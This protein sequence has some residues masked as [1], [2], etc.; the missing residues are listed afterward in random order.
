MGFFRRL[1]FCSSGRR[2]GIA[3]ALAA[4]LLACSK[5]QSGRADAGPGRASPAPSAAGAVPVGAAP[6]SRPS[7]LDSDVADRL[8]AVRHELGPGVKTEVVGATFVFVSADGGPLFARAV[9]DATRAFPLYLRGRLDHAPERAV[10]VYAFSREDRYLDDCDARFGEPC[11]TPFG[12]YRPAGRVI[13]VNL[14]RGTTTI[15]HEMLH[16]MTQRDFPLARRWLVEGLGSLYETPSFEPPGEIH[17]VT[18]WRLPELQRALASRARTGEVRL[19]RL[20]ATSDA[21]FGQPEGLLLRQATA[22]F[23]CQWLDEQGLLWPF[24]RQWRDAVASDPAGEASFARVV[25]TTPA[26]ASE[27]WRAWV[28]GLVVPPR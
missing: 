1:A 16:P 22:R 15:L 20:F 10:T 23:V 24:Y 4:A 25:G 13:E 6:P 11:D 26:E 8:A 12:Q 7:S 27:T 3:L 28:R 9:R 21:A 14:A 5:P 17:G 18:N 19:E 2:R